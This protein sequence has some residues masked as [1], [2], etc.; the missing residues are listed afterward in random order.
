LHLESV[1]AATR[2][3]TESTFQGSH[4]MGQEK[5]GPEGAEGLVGR[6]PAQS[7]ERGSDGGGVI[8]GAENLGKELRLV[9][10]LKNLRRASPE[11]F[12]GFD[13]FS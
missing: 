12:R 6:G 2:L 11:S 1:E 7:G 8:H 13:D 10:A 9:P 5:G 4:E 3:E